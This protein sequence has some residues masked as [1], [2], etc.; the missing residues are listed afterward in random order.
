M[1]PFLL[2]GYIS[3]DYFCDREKESEKIIN[4]IENQQDITLFAIRRIG[5]SALISHIFNH[6]D[7]NYDCLYVDLW[8]TTS[9]SGFINETASAVI[10]STI[11][12]KRSF[13][14]KLTDFIRSIGASLSIGNDGKPSVDII[15]HDRNQVFNRLEEI[16]QFL[17]GNSIPVI[18]AFD[19]F[20]EIKKYTDSMPLEAKLRSLVQRY[21]NIRFIF[22]GSEQHLISDIFS[23][24]DRPF[25]QSTRMIELKKIDTT[26]YHQFIKKHFQA[27]NK[28][29]T[30]TLISHVLTICH[31][32]TYYI[33]A[34][35][36]LIYSL[37]K[38]PETIE[39]FEDIYRDFIAE[40]QVFYTELPHR[41]TKHQFSTTKAVASYGKVEGVTTREFMTRAGIGSPGTMQAVI[42][43]LR[44]KQ[45]IIKENNYYRLYDVFLEHYLRYFGRTTR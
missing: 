10:Q 7:K 1:N 30:D 43:A 16:F 36:N 18:V 13:G 39:A 22:S 26:L 41:L 44:E 4:S 28:T 42:N 35:S 3:P 17:E 9:L 45:V 29:I 25:Y 14:K 40:K 34:I 32:H 24:I 2:K 19:E 5:K 38:I 20:Q 11:F 33:Q 15:I 8:G 6:L 12:S 31:G 21:H 27:G 37:D 23:S